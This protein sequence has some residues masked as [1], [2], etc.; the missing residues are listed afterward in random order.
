[1]TTRLRLEV[2]QR[3]AVKPADNFVRTAGQH[4]DSFVIVVKNGTKPI[5]TALGVD[6]AFVRVSNVHVRHIHRTRGQRV[7][8]QISVVIKTICLRHFSRRLAC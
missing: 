7:S 8:G 3:V 2:L 5:G 4:A 1:M 6:S